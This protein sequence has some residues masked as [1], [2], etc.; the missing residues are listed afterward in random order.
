MHAYS[1]TTAAVS[2][3]I[4]QAYWAP[5]SYTSIVV[6]SLTLSCSQ[7]VRLSSLLQGML[8]GPPGAQVS[9]GRGILDSGGANGRNLGRSIMDSGVLGAQRC[10]C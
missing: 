8:D 6:F 4:F 10:A 5:G 1:C 2:L 9:M 3:P 7:G